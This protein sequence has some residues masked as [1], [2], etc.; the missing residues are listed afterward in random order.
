MYTGG[1][2]EALL[3]SLGI[4]VRLQDSGEGVLSGNDHDCRIS[5]YHCFGGYLVFNVH[6]LASRRQ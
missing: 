5:D 4:P 2:I 3:M 1:K 6:L